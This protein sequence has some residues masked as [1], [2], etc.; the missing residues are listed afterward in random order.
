MKMS[1]QGIM[2]SEKAS[3]SLGVCPV[4]DR[5]AYLDDIVTGVI[6]SCSLKEFYIKEITMFF[7]ECAS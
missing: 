7:K 5:S 3:N 2:S 1:P 6:N 4:K